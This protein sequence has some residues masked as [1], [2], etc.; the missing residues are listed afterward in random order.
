MTQ[1]SPVPVFKA[2][3][4][5]GKPLAGGLLYT[6]IAGTSTPQ[7][8][9][10]D[11]SLSFPN[12]NPVVLDS[13]GE[14][15]LWLDPTLIYK[16]LLT[17]SLGN[18]IPNYPVDNISGGLSLTPLTVSLIPTPDNT[19]TLGSSSSSFAQLYLGVNHEPAL[20]LT[21]Q[22]IAYYPRTTGEV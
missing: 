17:D 7:A 19:L 5:D 8:T 12:T 14:S 11:S 15:P 6:Y 4:N 22:I 21:T 10:K 16:F 1:L 13:R 2:F 20:D 18:T 3:S 9:Y